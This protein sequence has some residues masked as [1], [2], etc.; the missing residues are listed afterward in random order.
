[1]FDIADNAYWMVACGG[2]GGGVIAKCPG[3]K[4]E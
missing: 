4:K 3:G 2:M 1:L